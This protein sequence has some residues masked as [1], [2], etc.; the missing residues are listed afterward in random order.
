MQIAIQLRAKLSREKLG[1]IKRLIHL[2]LK[3]VKQW[4]D[5]ETTM[6]HTVEEKVAMMYDD[7]TSLRSSLNYCMIQ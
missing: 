6:A 1:Q 2:I 7:I 5:E 3:D 4:Q